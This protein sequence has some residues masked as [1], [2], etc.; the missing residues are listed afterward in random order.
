M[1]SDHTLTVI[2]AFGP[3]FAGL[4]ALLAAWVAWLTF[5]LVGRKQIRLAQLQHQAEWESEFLKNYIDFWQNE[6]LADARYWISNDGGYEEIRSV[7]VRRLAG[8]GDLS[9]A[10]A[11]I[12]ETIDRFCARLAVYDAIGKASAEIESHID[13]VDQHKD[14][15][16]GAIRLRAELKSYIDKYWA[17][18]LDGGKQQV[19][20]RNPGNADA[21]FSPSSK[22]W[23]YRLWRK[24][25]VADAEPGS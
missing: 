15:W 24:G 13:W 21:P 16:H 20:G 1:S 6:S 5:R 10:D 17:S 11:D 14:Y 25:R 23:L 7:I 2:S 19:E 12:L 4:T 8:A 22:G 3:Y 18:L 9:R